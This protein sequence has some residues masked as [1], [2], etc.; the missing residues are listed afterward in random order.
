MYLKCEQKVNVYSMVNFAN[1]N[2]PGFSTR[3]Q[4]RICDRY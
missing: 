1:L 3:K 4:K 2:L